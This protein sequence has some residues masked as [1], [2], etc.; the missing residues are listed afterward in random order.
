MA[1]VLPESAPHDRR[2]SEDQAVLVQTLD[3]RLERYLQ[4]LH[5]HQT[6]QRDLAQQLSSVT[7]PSAFAYLCAEASVMLIEQGLSLPRPSQLRLPDWR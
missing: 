5:Q 7:A 2:S 3:H 6:L 1:E 4:L